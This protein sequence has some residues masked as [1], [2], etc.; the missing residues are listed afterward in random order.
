[1]SMMRVFLSRLV[2]LWKGSQ[3][4]RDLQDEIAAHLE[5]ATEEY[6]RN[7]LSRTEARRAALRDFGGIAQ[8]RE[9]HRD[10]RS[11]TWL[12]DGWQDLQYALRMLRRAPGF[13]AVVVVTLALGIGVNTALFGIVRQVL[14][15]NLA[16]A[17][18]EELV[19]VDCASPPGTTGGDMPCMHSYPAFRMLSERHPGL[20]GIAA[21][22]SVPNGLVASYHGTREVIT[23]Q[24][25]SANLFHVLGI[26]PSAGR[27]LE[28]PDDRR[29][30]SPVVVLSYGYWLRRFGGA[31]DVV[32]HALELNN[33]SV[34]I[35]GVLP[36]AF[37]G[38]TFGERYDVFL[39]LGTASLFFDPPSIGPSVPRGAS[40][41][42]LDATNRGW[43]TFLG[44]TLNGVPH[45]EI[46]KALVPVF[47][48][49]T[50]AALA[51]I[52]VD[53]RKRFDLTSDR[54]QVNVRSAA[55]GTASNMR[56][57]LEPTLR[58]LA[59]VSVLV[60]LI[61]CANIA[62][63]YVSQA[64]NRQR[65]FG[66]RFALGAGRSRLL[67]QVFTESLTVAAIGGGLGLVLAQWSGPLGFALATGD[68]GLHAIDLTAD[69]WMLTCALSLSAVTG[70]MVGAVSVFRVS[71]TNPHDALRPV[72]S[73]RSAQLT[74]ALLASQIALTMSLVGGASLLSQT[75]TNFRAIDLGFEPQPLTTLSMDSGF[76]ALGAA[77]ARQ[78][79]TQAPDSLASL[80]GVAS[81]TYA[82]RPVASGVPMFLAVEVPGFAGLGRESTASGLLYA[83]PAFVRTMG[84]TLLAGRDIEPMDRADAPPVAIIN[85]SFARHFFGEVDVIGRAFRLDRWITIV[86]VVGD[87]L[88]EGLKGTIQPMMYLPF[89]QGD[90]KALTFTI[91]S[92]QAATP[93]SETAR[94][95]L[96]RL[97]PAVGVARVEAVEA[98]LEEALRRERLLAVLGTIFSGLAL[99]L[100]AIGLYGMLNAT[101]TRRTVEIGVRTALGATRGGIARLIAG[102]T[103]AVFVSGLVLGG[104]GYAMAGHLIQSQLFGVALSDLR[105]VGA[106]VG[107]LTVIAA[108]AVWIPSRRATRISPAEALRHEEA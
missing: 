31:G 100:M 85:A 26:S 15:K 68:A 2:G 10:A 92:A 91:R 94:R 40:S 9:S 29:D 16:V 36:R 73:K 107:A 39:A 55:L 87:V 101:V 34:T 64:I 7:G 72:H 84:L 79:L 99:L 77:R 20:S 52:P 30:A 102:Q 45:E 67:R 54:I 63:L 78:Y 13:A 1:M 37:H 22:A 62:G 35:V 103:A 38:V 49:S 48:Q 33:R 86:G 74:K 42:I 80:P 75:L 50:E 24:L 98:Q 88:D 95:T 17:H 14:V 66:L 70:L 97:E 12:D 41:N 4:D 5:E 11:F 81:V 83:G 19:E 28:E 8:V 6:L 23:G 46:G 82:N 89:L 47:K 51:G 69:R 44:R 105:V 104:A 25:A 106:T 93:I 71:A 43:L 57:Q 53:I 3:F 56:S 21:F 32:G 90:S 58:V 27:L 59:V 108:V 96:E 76:S 60:L 65:E 18:P 61:A